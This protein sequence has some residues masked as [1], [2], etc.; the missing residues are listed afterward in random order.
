MN[1]WTIN[2]TTRELLD[3]QLDHMGTC[4]PSIPSYGNFWTLNYTIWELLNNQLHA[5]DL[6]NHKLHHT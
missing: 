5:N 3:P 1:F 4:E 2:Y 6:L